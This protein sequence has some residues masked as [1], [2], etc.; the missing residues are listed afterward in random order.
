MIEVW[1][2]DETNPALGPFIEAYQDHP[3]LE[4]EKLAETCSSGETIF[5]EPR[6]QR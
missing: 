2:Q 5:A 3:F 1:V 4:F 6:G